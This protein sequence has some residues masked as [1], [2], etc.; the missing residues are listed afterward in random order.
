MAVIA[1]FVNQEGNLDH[2]LL[3]LRE[4]EAT[5]AGVNLSALLVKIL[6]EYGI[7]NQIGYF[8]M[9]NS[10]NNDSML[11]SFAEYLSTL[12]L[13]FDPVHRRLRCTG[14]V[15]TLDVKSFLFGYSWEAVDDRHYQAGSDEE[16]ENWQKRGPLGRAYNIALHIRGSPQWIAEFKSL[17]G[18]RL[19]RRD[20]D[21]HWNSW[22]Q[23]ME[24][25]LLLKISAAMLDYT[26]NHML[27][28]VT[29]SPPATG[30]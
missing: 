1:H 9:D 20:N 16:I 19:I 14:H 4:I 24:S 15:I 26:A 29:A 11:D 18:G 10:T 28:E 7:W 27:L 3:G 6:S 12:N 8:M 5:H 2:L 30:L 21:T 13:N 22:F 25:M 23:M 17:S